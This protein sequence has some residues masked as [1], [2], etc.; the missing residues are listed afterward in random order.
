[1]LNLIEVDGSE[2]ELAIAGHAKPKGGRGAYGTT[3]TRA[4]HIDLAGATTQT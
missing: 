4:T 1:V 2:D 3:S